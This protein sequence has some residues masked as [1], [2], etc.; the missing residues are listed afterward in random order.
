MKKVNIN[1]FEY[2][3]V[4]RNTTALVWVLVNNL[5]NQLTPDNKYRINDIITRLNVRSFNYSLN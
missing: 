5:A 1:G 3:Y 4:T 2:M